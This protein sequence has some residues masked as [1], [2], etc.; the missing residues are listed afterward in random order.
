MPIAVS[1]VEYDTTT[2]TVEKEPFK[3]DL[4]LLDMGVYRP[5]AWSNTTGVSNARKFVLGLRFQG[6]GAKN[7]KIWMDGDRAD[8]YL[9]N[10]DEPNIRINHEKK[11]Y[12][13][14]ITN[15]DDTRSALLKPVKVAT[16]SA[17]PFSPI[18]SNGVGGVGANL[19]ATIASELSTIDTITINVGDRVLVKNQASAF[20]NGIYVV[21][22]K[23]SVSTGYIL[24]R[25]DDLNQ[26]YEICRGL[27]VNV[28]QSG[29]ST[30]HGN[31]AIWLAA[32]ATDPPYTM[33]TSGMYWVENA[34]GDNVLSH[35]IV[36]TQSDV[37][38]MATGAPKVVDGVTLRQLD[39]VLVRSQSNAAENGIY[40]VTDPGSGSD[41][42][43][44]RATDL[45]QDI[46]ISPLLMVKVQ[47][48]TDADKV[49][50][51]NLA[52]APPWT[53]NTTNLA[54]EPGNVAIVNTYA[55]A[56]SRWNPFPNTYGT[57]MDL[58]ETSLTKYYDAYSDRFGLAAYVPSGEPDQDLRNFFV[59]AEFDTS[60]E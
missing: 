10:N 13:F 33:G 53:I 23:G 12:I 19:T 17:L 40:R 51:L 36:A 4:P 50:V 45:N 20:E 27:R 43:W 6:M 52:T 37:A 8:F 58:G 44:I 30:Q 32:S 57:A 9:K 55:D 47:K 31:W 35:C 22:S 26:N 46:D 29:S 3:H 34:Q 21:T 11:G 18:Y 1:W 7:I 60:D 25:A 48:G 39:R 49:F 42:S 59:M 38:D 14:K 15:L 28:P 16:D 41:G 54:F 56:V 2:P 24:T 5:D